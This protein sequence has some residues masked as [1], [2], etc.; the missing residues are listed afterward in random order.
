MREMAEVQR[1]E[2]LE[3]AINLIKS[4]KNPEQVMAELANRLT[5]KLIH[6][7]SVQLKKAGYDNRLDF[8]D[9]A[10]ELYNLKDHDL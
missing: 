10:R 4:G 2:E 5:N 8:L 3:R 9:T 7:P 1:N 6:T